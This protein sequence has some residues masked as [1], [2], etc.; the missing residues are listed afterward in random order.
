M[1]VRRCLLRQGQEHGLH[2]I[3]RQMH[4]PGDMAKRRR[5]GKV[6]VPPNQLS[7]C[8]FGISVSVISEQSKRPSEC[9]LADG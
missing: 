3:L 2:D 4:L 7:E 8:W 9:P 5:V 6:Y 1:R